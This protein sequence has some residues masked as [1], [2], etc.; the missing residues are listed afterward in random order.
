MNYLSKLKPNE[1]F[2]PYLVNN[3]SVGI[4]WALN[5]KSVQKH[6]SVVQE[7]QSLSLQMSKIPLCIY[8]GPYP[9][10]SEQRAMRQAIVIQEEA[11]EL[12]C[13]L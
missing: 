12:V 10:H 8:R 9:S 7:L 6:K 5:D 1:D 11:Y 3:V 13:D 2:H 4:L